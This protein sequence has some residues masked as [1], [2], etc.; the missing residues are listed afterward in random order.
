MIRIRKWTIPFII[1]F[2][3]PGVLCGGSGPRAASRVSFD[4]NS[5]EWKCRITGDVTEG[6]YLTKLLGMGEVTRQSVM[7]T[8]R[9]NWDEGLFYHGSA[10]STTHNDPAS[11]VNF[12]SRQYMGRERKGYGYNCTG[13]VA[14][15]LYY[16]NG[17]STEDALHKMKDLYRPLSR[18]G[19]FTDGTG[20]YYFL[21][22][23][24]K[25]FYPGEVTDVESI[26]TVMGAA[27]REGKLREGY[28]LFFWPS[29]GWDCHFGIYAGKGTDGVYRMYHAAGTLHSGVKMNSSIDLTPVTSEGPSYMYV[30]P[31]PDEEG[32]VP[33]G[34]PG[35]QKTGGKQYHFYRTGKMTFGWFTEKGEWYFFDPATGEMAVGW[36][37]VSGKRYY[38]LENGRMA[39]NCMYGVSILGP[40]GVLWTPG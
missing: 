32:E 5:L 3:I 37:E 17:G 18:G 1:F 23:K 30:I 31:L 40:D 12:G 4:E 10:Y 35:W 7:E 6:E 39:R 13:F 29:T 34:E 19:S 24:V 16:A 36:R 8:L 22:N 14:S 9:A 27:D 25:V 26:Q 11:C 2:L 33:V 21:E 28:I 20:W 15:V 38:F